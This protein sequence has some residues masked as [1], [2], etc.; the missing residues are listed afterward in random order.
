MT[1][2]RYNPMTDL[3][4]SLGNFL[5]FANGDE[6]FLRFVPKVNTLENAKE[7]LL[8][9]EL[10]GIEKEDIDI[11]I[12]ADMLTISGERKTKNEIKAEDYYKL[13]SSFGKFQRSFSLP[14]NAD[15]DAIAAKTKNGMLE[16]VIPKLEIEE[17]KKIQIA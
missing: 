16:I 4:K 8:E 14:K 17:K 3:E 7:Y 9:M 11:N 2:A 1:I 13:E 5:N 12:D 10:P 15:K 6:G